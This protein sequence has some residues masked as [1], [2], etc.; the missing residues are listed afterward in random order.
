M[1]VIIKEVKTKKDLKKFIKFPFK[2]YKNNKYWVPPLLSDEL[3]TLDKEKNPAFEHCEAKYFLAYKNGKIVGRV[4]AILNKKFNEIWNKKNV[5]FGW[6]DFID[7]IEVSSALLNAVENYAK[8]LG[9][10]EIHGPLGFTDFDYEG[11]L[12]EGFEELPTIATIYNYPYYPKHMEQ[13]GYTKDE[14]WV[15]MEIKI[16]QQ[17]DSKVERIAEMVKKR[18]KLHFWDGKSSK[19]IVPYAKSIFKLLNETYSHLYGFVPLSEAQMDL[20]T[21]Q[22]LGFLDLKYTKL[23]LDEENKL[24]AVGITMPSLSKAFQKAK[25][26]LFPFGFLHIL[27]AMKKNDTIDLYLVGVRKD[28]QGKGVNALLMNELT[29]IYLENGFKKA[30]TNP[31]LENNENVQA[32]WKFY[33]KRIHKRRRAFKKEI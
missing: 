29:K 4:A 2:L 15:E 17:P 9:M 32:Q 20:Y 5:R 26:K 23:I 21:K 3:N 19:E 33:E 28:L 16:P 31:E 11:M 24:A 6:I 8:E 27:K 22:Y 1:D 7:D 13:L 25:G 18:L 14:D 30:E 10:T 12:I